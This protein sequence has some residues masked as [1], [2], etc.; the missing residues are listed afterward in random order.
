MSGSC[1]SAG[2]AFI[3]PKVTGVEVASNKYRHV[4]RR[5]LDELPDVIR[6]ATND[7]GKQKRQL[8]F[9]LESHVSDAMATIE[10]FNRQFQLGKE[11][12]TAV[13]WAWPFEAGPAMFHIVQTYTKASQFQD[14]TAEESYRLQRVGGSILSMVN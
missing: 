6:N 3:S 13:D 9:S 2:S 1:A 7:I 5:I 4:S 10:R 11:E 8:K 12:R 14:L